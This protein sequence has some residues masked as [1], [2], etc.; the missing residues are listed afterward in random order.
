MWG[1]G[2]EKCVMDTTKLPVGVVGE[3]K[4][5]SIDQKRMRGLIEVN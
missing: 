1:H 5:G 3:A 2:K 4:R